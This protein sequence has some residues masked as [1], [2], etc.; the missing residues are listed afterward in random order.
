ME[1]LRAPALFVLAIL[2]ISL[3]GATIQQG[4]DIVDRRGTV[5]DDYYAAGGTVTIDAD[6][7]GDVIAAGGT[8]VVGNRVQQDVMVAGGTVTVRGQV[9][10]DVRAA[11]GDVTIDAQVADDTLA[12]GGNVTITSDARVGGDAFLAGGDVTINGTVNG[13]LKAAG[14]TVTINGTVHG[15]VD[16]QAEKVVIASDARID[17]DLNYRSPEKGRINKEAVIHGK[18]NYAKGERY[19]PHPVARFL[20]V[21][22]FSVAGIVVLLMFPRFTSA[23]TARM[24]RDFWKNLGLGFALLVATPVAFVL[25]MISFVGIWVGL[26]LLAIYLVSL[27]LA[28]ILAAF[29][30]AGTG[31]SMFHFDTGSRGRMIVALIV[32][33]LLLTALRF[34]PVLGGLVTFLLMLTALGATVFQLHDLYRGGEKKAAAAPVKKQTSRSKK[35]SRSRGRS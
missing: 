15:N 32:A 18:T 1:K 11:G 22:T 9:Q 31:A 29:F 34:I 8:V 27:V 13:D 23:T 16:V 5:N 3:V 19:R 2:C 6:V 17:G 12:S 20:S 35:S 7:R 24:G 21:I 10:D 25:L 33:L 28:Y 30:V 26:P 14:G 4:G